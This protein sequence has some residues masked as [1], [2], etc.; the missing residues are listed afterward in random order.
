MHPRERSSGI[1]E[2]I[3]SNCKQF[4]RQGGDPL[5]KQTPFIAFSRILPHAIEEFPS[6]FQTIVGPK[7]IRADQVLFPIAFR[8][9]NKMGVRHSPLRESPMGCHVDARNLTKG[10]FAMNSIRVVS[11]FQVY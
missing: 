1:K 6:D 3:P 10:A 9:T 7:K 2:L 11:D 4:R 5:Q 8:L